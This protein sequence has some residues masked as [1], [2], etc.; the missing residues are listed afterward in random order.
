MTAAEITR[1]VAE[2]IQEQTFGSL[3]S[4]KVQIG[5]ATSPADGT[6]LDSLIAAA[7]LRIQP[8]DVLT[9]F[10]PSIH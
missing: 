9:Q 4:L 10:P 6:N 3:G 1:R 7:R 5:I 8:V 2:R